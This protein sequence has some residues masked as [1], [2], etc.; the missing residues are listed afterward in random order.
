MCRVKMGQL[1]GRLGKKHCRQ[2]DQV[3][4]KWQA[5]K[6]LVFLRNM[7]GAVRHSERRNYDMGISQAAATGRLY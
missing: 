4:E 2:K 1:S 5:E 7:K 6:G 3:V